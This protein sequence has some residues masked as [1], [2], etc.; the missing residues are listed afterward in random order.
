M[1]EHQDC[2]KFFERLSELVDG[3]LDRVTGDQILAHLESCPE[4][5]VCWTTFK[6]SVEIFRNL[7]P[8]PVPED[9]VPRI[10]EFI[11]DHL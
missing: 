11:S 9:F 7:G 6:K 10:K 2:R 5:R 8:E 3:E 4:C 1:S